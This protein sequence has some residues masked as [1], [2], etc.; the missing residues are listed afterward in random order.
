MAHFKFFCDP[1][2]G[3]EPPV[4]NPASSNTLDVV[5]SKIVLVFYV[6]LLKR[7]FVISLIFQAVPETWCDG[8]PVGNTSSI[9]NEIARVV[10][11][12]VAKLLL[13]GSIQ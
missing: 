7:Y 11:R 12:K 6:V 13:H 10:G 1:S 4:E 9:S 8:P 3:H 2:L 5:G